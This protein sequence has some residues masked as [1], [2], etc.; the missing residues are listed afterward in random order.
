MLA[1]KPFGTTIR[2]PDEQPAPGGPIL[3]DCRA[4]ALA[5][6]NREAKGEL[7]LRA[8]TRG[9]EESGYDVRFGQEPYCAGPARSR[10]ALA[11]IAILGGAFLAVAGVKSAHCPQTTRQPH[12]LSR[13]RWCRKELAHVLLHDGV[14]AGARRELAEVEA[15]SVAY[16]VCHAAGLASDDYSLPYVARWSGGDP[17]QVRL[18]AERVIT[19]A[20]RVLEAAGLGALAEEVVPT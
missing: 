14:Q 12:G 15:E 16:L 17:A 9:A 4:P 3:A 19:T 1:L 20:R 10:L 8:V 13:L 2:L 7:A 5:A 11:L 6:W 18:T